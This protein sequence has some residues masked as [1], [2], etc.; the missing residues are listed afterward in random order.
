MVL[1]EFGKSQSIDT[2][3]LRRFRDTARDFFKA[4]SISFWFLESLLGSYFWRTYG[5]V[6]LRMGNPPPLHQLWS[7]QLSLQHSP[8]SVRSHSHRSGVAW[9]VLGGNMNGKKLFFGK[10]PWCFFPQ[11]KNCLVMVYDHR[12][13]LLT[14]DSIYQVFIQ[15]IIWQYL[16]IKKWEKWPSD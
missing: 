14:K 3:P 7:E 15:C 13:L 1:Y 2:W 12:A 10:P 6:S 4:S 5:L 9:V 8:E 11:S 16:T